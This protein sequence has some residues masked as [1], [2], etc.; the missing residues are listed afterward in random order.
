MLLLCCF[1]V[2][3]SNSS[4]RTCGVAVPPGTIGHCSTGSRLYGCF[5]SCCWCF[6][7]SGAVTPLTSPPPA[8][9]SGVLQPSDT[10]SHRN[11]GS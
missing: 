7:S 9:T 8:F 10:T 5:W 6:P 4:S 3:H 1:A 2:V 11:V